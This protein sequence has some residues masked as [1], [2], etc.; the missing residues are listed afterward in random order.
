MKATFLGTNGWYDTVTG[1]TVCILIETELYDIVLDAGNGIH[2]LDGYVSGRKPVFIFLSHFHLDHIAG[3][4]VLG[5]FKFERGLVI[6]GPEGTKKNLAML[7]AQPFSMPFAQLEYRTG[8]LE[9]PAEINRLPFNVE[10][11]PLRHASLTLGYRLRIDGK[12][13]S[14]CPDTGFCENALKLAADADLLIAECAYRPGQVV[15]SWPHLNPETAARIAVEARAKLLHLVHF[16]A[17]LYPALDDRRVAE[18]T[19]R[20]VFLRTVASHDGMQVGI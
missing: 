7:I 11:L 5:K 15:E 2:K 6:C 17:S 1:N 16:D 19:A 9:L 13:V 4:H 3:L 8:I 20:K 14:Y 12:T 10:A 18:E